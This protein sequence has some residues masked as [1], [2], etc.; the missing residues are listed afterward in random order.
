MMLFQ[1]YVQL[2]SELGIECISSECTYTLECLAVDPKIGKCYSIHFFV[3]LVY[4]HIEN[5]KSAFF[6][7]NYIQ[8]S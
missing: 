8:K 3:C 6:A 5:L 2:E 1:D 4:R 7:Y